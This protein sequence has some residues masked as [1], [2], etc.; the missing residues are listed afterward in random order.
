MLW[1]VV[2]FAF[3]FSVLGFVSYALVRPFTHFG[4]T[5]PQDR[6]WRPLD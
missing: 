6:I 1:V 4:Y 5:H 2:T 3:V